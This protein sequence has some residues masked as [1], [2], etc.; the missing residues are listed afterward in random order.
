LF[1]IAQIVCVDDVTRLCTRLKKP[2]EYTLLIKKKV[3]LEDYS[4]IC[5]KFI[6]GV[7]G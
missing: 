3:K 5:P 7:C 2:L 6:L 4:G 1:F